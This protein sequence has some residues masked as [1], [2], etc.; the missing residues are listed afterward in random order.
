MN[1]MKIGYAFLLLLAFVR[2][3]W[4]DAD[5]TI[6]FHKDGTYTYEGKNYTLERFPIEEVIKDHPIDSITGTTVR[7][8]PEGPVTIEELIAGVRPLAR[9]FHKLGVGVETRFGGKVIPYLIQ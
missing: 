5:K 6:Y 9:K 2:P 4:C 1:P 3:G 7:I 8:F